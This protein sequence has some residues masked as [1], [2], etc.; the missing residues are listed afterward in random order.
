MGALFAG[1]IFGTYGFFVAKTAL[2]D[3]NVK[4]IGFGGALMV[5][6]YF[7][8]NPWLCWG[9]GLFLSVFAFKALKSG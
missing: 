7:I 4:A 3:A 8:S 2:R 1:L 5:Y 9:I 6:S